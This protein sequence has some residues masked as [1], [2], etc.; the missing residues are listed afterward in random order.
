MTKANLLANIQNAVQSVIHDTGNMKGR[1]LHGLTELMAELD[2]IITESLPRALTG[3]ANAVANLAYC[4][5]IAILRAARISEEFAA[6]EI[7]QLGTVVLESIKA[8]LPQPLHALADGI[9]AAVEQVVANQTAPAPTT[10]APDPLVIAAPTPA[11]AAVT[12]PPQESPVVPVAAPVVPAAPA[13]VAAV[14]AVAATGS[15]QA[16]ATP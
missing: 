11:P 14:P 16:I 2:P 6:S 7:Q 15:T 8:A 10:F 12:A 5:D 3:D 9:Q 4:K 1:W 13:P